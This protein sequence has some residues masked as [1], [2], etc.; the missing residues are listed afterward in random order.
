MMKGAVLV[1]VVLA[2]LSTMPM[3]GAYDATFPW[4]GTYYFTCSDYPTCP[5]NMSFVFLNMA[6]AGGGGKGVSWSGLYERWG[7]GGSAGEYGNLTMVPLSYST[8]Y[9]VI[10]G[11]GGATGPAE[12]LSYSGTDT[13]AF[14]YTK[15]G[16]AGGITGGT[17]A[18]NGGNGESTNYLLTTPPATSGGSI[19]PYTGGIGG[20]GYGSGGGGAASNGSAVYGS[21]TTT[22]G[23]G[24]DGYVRLWDMNGSAANIPAYTANPTSVGYGQTVTFTDQSILN[25]INNLTY[26]WDF[27]DGGTSTTRGTANHVYSTYGVFTTNLTLTSDVSTS[28]LNKSD[29]ITVTNIPITAWWTQR[30]I[31]F[32]IVDAYGADLS[33]AN[34]SV[35]YITNSL[36]SKD[37]SYLVSAFGISQTVANQMTNG[38]VAMY[39]MTG[40]NGDISFMMFPAIQYGISI[41]NVSVGLSKYIEIY[42]TDTE[43]LIRCPLSTQAQSTNMLTAMSNTSLYVTEPNSSYITW[44]LQYQDGEG[45]TTALTWNVTCWNNM[46]VM[47][48]N[49]WGALAAGEMV[50][51]NYTFPS[52]PVGMEYRAILNATRVTP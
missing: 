39:G 46:T 45:Y 19:S 31:K 7:Y 33:M 35:T 37:P 6:A 52:T 30:L 20:T 21:V 43:Y 49:S 36:P 29:Y 48:S 15:H 2:V 5:S 42:P 32:K 27:G 4:G 23:A 38:S 24:M 22:G 50:L 10:V 28:Y 9:T 44:N 13:V 12:G 51:D 26:L 40:T 14:G 47:H 41:T 1:V 18:A 3:V 34:V 11:E 25:D 17:S 8:N 16:G